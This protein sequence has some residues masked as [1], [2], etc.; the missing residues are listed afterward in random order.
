MVTP[1]LNALLGSLVVTVGFWFIWGALPIAWSLAIAL[2]VAGFL[3]WQ[4]RTIGLVWAWST[5]LL[6]LESLAWPIATMVQVRLTTAQPTDEQM[7]EIL[8]AVLFGL[9]SS[10]FWIAFAFG[11][12]KRARQLAAPTPPS[13]SAPPEGAKGGKNA[14][15]PG[16]R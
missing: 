12:F 2:G 14:R 9:F 3:A 16:P 11:L 8:N 13:S 1:P 5:L 4:G 6:G 15:Q 7:G 10:V